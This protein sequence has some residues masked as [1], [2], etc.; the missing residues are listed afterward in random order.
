MPLLGFGWPRWHVMQPMCASSSMLAMVC[1]ESFSMPV[2]WIMPRAMF[3][4]FLSSDAHLPPET[5][6][7]VQCDP[8]EREN[9]PIAPSRRTASTPLNAFT[10]SNTE[11]AAM[12][13]LPAIFARRAVMALT[14]GSF[15]SGGAIVCPGAPRSALGRGLLRRGV[16]GPAGDA[17]GNPAGKG[18]GGDITQGGSHRRAPPCGVGAA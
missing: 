5:W 17:Q 3:F 1:S 6:Q 2:K 12:C 8:S 16:G 18:E 14:S 13:S 10:F 7:S 11:S 9:A 15:V 4:S